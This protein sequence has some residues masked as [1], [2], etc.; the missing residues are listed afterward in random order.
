MGACDVEVREGTGVGMRDM[1]ALKGGD[2]GA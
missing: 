1:G 2:G